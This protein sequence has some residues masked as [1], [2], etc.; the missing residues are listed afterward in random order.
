MKKYRIIYI[1]RKI[2]LIGFITAASI[3]TL[4]IYFCIVNS[5]KN[6]FINSYTKIVVIDP[7]HGG[8]DGGTSKDGIL[9]K[10]I[11]LDISKRIKALLEQKGYKVILTRETDTSLDNLT[12]ISGSRHQKDLKARTDIINNSN[13]QL[14]LSIHGNCHIKNL[15]ADG[16]IVLYNDRFTQNKEIAYSIQRALNNIIINGKKRT[17][18]S[19][20]S[21][22]TFYLLNCTKIPGVIIETAFV[23]NQVERQLLM[24]D[25]FKDE[26]ANAIVGGIE[27]YL[28]EIKRI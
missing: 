5:Y 28:K 16:S 17:M 2:S 14:F 11:N 25:M 22:S 4:I 18:H 7:G 12:N 27:I 23:S 21:H 9:E 6:N 13:A 26:I 24:Q 1:S 20:E 8:I 15:N 19:P 3:V 10:D